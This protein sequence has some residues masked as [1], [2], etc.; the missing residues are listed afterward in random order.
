VRSVVKI[1]TRY[2][3]SFLNERL[4]RSWTFSAK[5]W[6][7]NSD[8]ATAPVHAFPFLYLATAPVH[9]FPFL[10]LATAPVHAFPCL[11]LATA[12][13]HAIPSSLFPENIIRRNMYW[14]NSGE[15]K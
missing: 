7:I 1:S 13:V 14:D 9:A 5:C 11:Y 12:P 10:Y 8:L 2:L 3:Q 6:N 4:R 15:F